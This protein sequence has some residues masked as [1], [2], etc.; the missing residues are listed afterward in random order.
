[1]LPPSALN[2][3]E[4]MY[5]QR[6]RALLVLCLSIVLNSACAGHATR[7]QPTIRPTHL[8]GIAFPQT[9]EIHVKATPY[10]DAFLTS[11]VNQERYDA[12]PYD[13]TLSVNGTDMRIDF[14]RSA[15]LADIESAITSHSEI[16]FGSWH[17]DGQTWLLDSSVFF[18][19]DTPA[20]MKSIEGGVM[21]TAIA[22]RRLVNNPD[23]PSDYCFN[24]LLIGDTGWTDGMTCAPNESGLLSV[25]KL[26]DADFRLDQAETP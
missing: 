20:K 21:V 22:T 2:E 4:Q 12:C 13:V 19:L 15:T 25:M 16:H 17:F 7:R 1:M 8:C 14:S 18:P 9:G 3:P 23:A 5:S 10:T 11:R 26:R 6:T 24:L